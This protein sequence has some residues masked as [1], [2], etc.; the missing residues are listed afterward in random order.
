MNIIKLIQTAIG[1][2]VFLVVMLF[3]WRFIDRMTC[4]LEQHGPKAGISYGTNTCCQAIANSAKPSA[5]DPSEK[6]DSAAIIS[7][8]DS[9]SNELSSWMAIMGIFATVFGLLIPIGSY[10]LQRQ[11]L[12]DEREAI[13][14][15]VE[16][17]SAEVFAKIQESVDE[18][19]EEM[20]EKMK[21]MWNFLAAN[22]DR[23]LVNDGARLIGSRSCKTH[24]DRYSL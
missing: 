6:N 17:S 4:V 11:S 5:I 20:A 2:F 24:R 18:M 8:Y 3:A 21:P 7:A 23:F 10:F 22:F 13:M 9:L 19:P 15:D 1:A 16:K 12:K 14:R